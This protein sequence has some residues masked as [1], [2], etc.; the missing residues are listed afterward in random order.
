MTPTI[1]SSTNTPTTAP[2]TPASTDSLASLGSNFNTFLTML[3]TQL[4]NQDP[5]APLDTNQF[6]Q[7]LISMTGVEQQIKVNS[8][9][10]SLI[11]MGQTNQALAA[12]PLV[13]KT[14]EYDAASSTLSSGSAQFSYTLPA[15]AAATSISVVDANG[16]VVFQTAGETGSGRHGFTWNGKTA[17]GATLP[18]GTYSIQVSALDAKN[19]PVTATTSGFGKV[20]GIEVQQ[21]QPMMNIGGVLIPT[22]KLIAVDSAS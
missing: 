6:T 14:V 5:T 15:Q 13:G 7:Q 10:S 2:T 21:G 19:Q 4:K 11:S 20:T 9:L 8:Q 17:G 16:K 22:A 1:A 3:T 12:L 18:D